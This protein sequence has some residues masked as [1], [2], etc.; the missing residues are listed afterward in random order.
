MAV[1]QAKRRGLWRDAWYPNYNFQMTPRQLV[2]LASCIDRIKDIEGSIVEIGCAHGLTTTFLYEYMRASAFKKHYVCIDTFSGFTESDVKVEV[3]S[4]GK[5]GS[6]YDHP[7]TDNRREWFL[8]ALAKRDITDL[9]VMQADVTQL[10]ADKLPEK[11]AFCLVDVD[12]Y[13]PV[14]VALGKI[15]PRM[16]EGGIIVTDDCW[17]TSTYGFV[18]T[19]VASIYDGAMQAYREFIAEKGLPERLVEDKLGIIDL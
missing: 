11:I 17:S 10:S 3:D 19:D 7:F 14:K 8:E 5:E 12:L 9:E 2:F 13:Q 6:H 18:K 4:R 1:S 15:F 16:A